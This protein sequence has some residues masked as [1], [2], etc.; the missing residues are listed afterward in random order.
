ML[1]DKNG[2][3]LKPQDYI[4]ICDKYLVQIY[5]FPN[6]GIGIA[7]KDICNGPCNID[8]NCLKPNHRK[9]G[10]TQGLIPLSFLDM[11]KIE[12]CTKEERPELCI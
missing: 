9:I 8:L 3:I 1:K 6:V 12:K 10:N 2:T 4:C 7:V 5:E 11:T